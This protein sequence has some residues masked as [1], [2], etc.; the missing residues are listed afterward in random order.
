MAEQYV[1]EIFE[2]EFDKPMK[3][4]FSCVKTLVSMDNIRMKSQNIFLVLMKIFKLQV[5]TY[6]FFNKHGTAFIMLNTDINGY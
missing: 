4:Q 1:E 5:W 2:D 6:K 3:T